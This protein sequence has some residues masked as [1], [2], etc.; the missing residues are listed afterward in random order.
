ME[1]RANFILIGVFTLLGIF[2]ALG[3]FIWLAS[4]QLDRQFAQYGILF[5]DVSGLDASADVFF[6]G[7]KV[8]R[9]TGIRIWDQNPAQVYVGV[10]I[11]AATPIRADTVA[12]LSAS[13]VTGVA[14]IS[15]SGG[16]PTAEALLRADDTAPIIRSRRSTVQALVQDAPDILTDAA[17]VMKQLQAITGP[18]NQAAI[19]SILQNLDTASGQLEQAL[20][21]FSDIS[22]TVSDATSQ[23][24]GFTDRLDS[25]GSD[26]QATLDQTL[27]QANTTLTAVT[28]A[29]DAFS[30]VVTG[31][32]ALLIAQTREA[33]ASATAAI[34]GVTADLRDATRGLDPLVGNATQTLERARQTMDTLDQALV[35][36]QDAFD[37]ATGLM[38][39]DLAPVLDDIRTA[40]ADLSDAVARVTA[41]VPGITADTR[42]M[43]ARA[44]AVVAEVQGT[45]AAMAPGLRAFSQTGL[46]QYTQLSAEARA[47]VRTMNDLVR[48]IAQ[49]PGRFLLDN[50]VPEYRR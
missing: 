26:L 7:V 38:D 35:S 19:A 28:E 16:S 1:T 6:N 12:E 42:A 45:V 9:V 39:I 8:G 4:V 41:D 36:A 49:D 22:R 24:S 48:R 5:D 34:D 14:Y 17:T 30:G 43:I 25:I 33:V 29:A 44:D 13:G 15:L 11:D 18:D 3:F 40:A 27:T 32:G 46:A 50:R 47:L 2:G 21:D 37:S 23:I 31:D 10:E 20:Q